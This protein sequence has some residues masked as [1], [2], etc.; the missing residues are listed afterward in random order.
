MGKKEQLYYLVKAFL[1]NEYSIDSFCDT[2][3]NVFF[4]D[5]PYNELNSN[6]LFLF[7]SL[8]EIVVKFSPFDEDLEAYPGVYRNAEDVKNAIRSVADKLEL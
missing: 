2:F 6:E 8:A 4:P 7:E 5:V 1:R 3:E